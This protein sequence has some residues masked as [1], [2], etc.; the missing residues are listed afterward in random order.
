[1]YNDITGINNIEYSGYYQDVK[2]RKL[3][4][5]PVFTTICLLLLSLS[6]CSNYVESVEINDVLSVNDIQITLTVKDNADGYSILKITEADGS[7]YVKIEVAD[8]FSLRG[9]AAI[10]PGDRYRLSLTVMNND[11]DPV[12]SY[13]FWKLP[14]TSLR[15]YTF[16]GEN[17]NPPSSVTQESYTKWTTFDETFETR[18]GED[19]FLMTLLSFKGTFYIKDIS[20]E[21]LD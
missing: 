2:M 8:E 20:I 19:S 17:G 14:V 3:K 4:I 7:S 18:E 10:K 5:V 15:H 6:A 21:L 12:I 9:E 13:S 11:A 16:N 1:M